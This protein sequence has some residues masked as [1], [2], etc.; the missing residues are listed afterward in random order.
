MGDLSRNFSRDEF[1]CRGPVNQNFGGDCCGGAAP[2]SLELVKKLQKIRDGFGGAVHITS[3]FR[4]V[5]Y[6][7]F[8]GGAAD[9]QHL[10][11]L[12]ADI[13]PLSGDFKGLVQA[14]MDNIVSGG[15]GLYPEKNFIHVDIRPGAVA[16]WGEL[17]GETVTFA[18]ALDAIGLPSLVLDV[19]RDGLAQ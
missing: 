12:A 7:S 3:G 8:V 16:R 14:V 4:C 2:V 18:A 17:H 10:Y 19:Y 6:N 1:C 5:K 11:G 9:S 13:S 15:C